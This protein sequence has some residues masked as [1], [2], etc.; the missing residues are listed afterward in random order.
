MTVGIYAIICN[1][2]WRSYVGQS[3]N[4]EK[5]VKTHFQLL[6]DNKHQNKTLQSDFNLYGLASFTSEIIEVVSDKAQLIQRE[7]Y[8]ELF[9]CNLYNATVVGYHPIPQLSEKQISYY[10]SFVKI[11]D[12]NECWLWTG[13]VR[14]G[15]GKIKLRQKQ[16][17]AHR[18]SF[19]LKNS[20]ADNNVVVRHKCNNKLCCNP[21]HLITGTIQENKRDT[22]NALNNFTLNRAHVLDIRDKFSKNPNICES[23][24][25][26]WFFDKYGI[27][28]SRS[29]LIDVGLGLRWGDDDYIPPIRS[30]RKLNFELADEIRALSRSGNSYGKIIKDF[31]VRYHIS[32]SASVI[33][34]IINNKLY[35]RV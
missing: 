24:M 23:K 32:I 25:A 26:E 22:R 4:I 14:N 10:W 30:G 29:Y 31:N 27:T 33:S 11:T 13:A 5:R 19:F 1:K 9:G 17:S 18:L 16:I 35:K 8:Y 34:R 20:N 15:Y 21:N 28:M 6:R 3:V 7:K 2:T 12:I